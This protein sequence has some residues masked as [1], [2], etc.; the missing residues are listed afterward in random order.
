L[1]ARELPLHVTAQ[2]FWQ[3]HLKPSSS[4]K[5]VLEVP[6]QWSKVLGPSLSQ[7]VHRRQLP[8][9]G[10]GRLER[11]AAAE[12]AVMA[13]FLLSAALPVTFL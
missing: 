12:D 3:W 2:D 13:G 11:T 9:K 6:C 4:A 5:A 1:A 7:L 10:R 8:R